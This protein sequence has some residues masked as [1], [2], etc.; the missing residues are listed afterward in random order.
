MEDSCLS[1]VNEGNQTSRFV[2]LYSLSE[3]DMIGDLGNST[4]WLL[5]VL[6]MNVEGRK[7]HQNCD[8]SS[9]ERFVSF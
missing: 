7:Y 1:D 4:K 8:F 3:V 2:A 9:V 5:L 6:T